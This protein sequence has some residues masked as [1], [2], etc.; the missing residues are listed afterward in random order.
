[1]SQKIIFVILCISKLSTVFM[2][3][4]TTKDVFVTI[5]EIMTAIASLSIISFP[6]I[7]ANGLILN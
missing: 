2:T 3:E 6:L 7:P 5:L 4:M 1:M